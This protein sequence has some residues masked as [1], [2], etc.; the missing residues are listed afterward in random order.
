MLVDILM[1]RPVTFLRK[2]IAA[3]N[4][5]GYHAAS[6][7]A[8]VEKMLLHSERFQHITMAPKKAR[9]EAQ[10]AAGKKLGAASKA[11]AAARA[12]SKPAAA[13]KAA[14]APKAPKA[15][16][17]DK[18]AVKAA[19]AAA[20]EAARAEKV[21]AKAAVK[22]EKAAEKAAKVAA[23]PAASKRIPR[24]KKA[25]PPFKGKMNVVKK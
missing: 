5:K 14:K 19:K 15:S 18:A 25:L 3:A 23:K 9:S 21:A 12:A 20:R 22:A 17:A 2:A 10:I 1:S 11:R 7:K 8:V 24:P 4:I 6:K 13:P 16:E